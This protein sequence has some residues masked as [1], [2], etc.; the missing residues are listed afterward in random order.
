MDEVAGS[1]RHLQINKLE[2]DIGVLNE[3]ALEAAVFSQLPGH[4]EAE[5]KKTLAAGRRGKTPGFDDDKVDPQQMPN[6][7]Y[8]DSSRHVFL[9]LSYFLKHGSF[10]W[11]AASVGFDKFEKKAAR[12]FQQGFPGLAADLKAVLKQ[13]NPATER[14]SLQFSGDFLADVI[15]FLTAGKKETISEILDSLKTVLRQA[16][17]IATPGQFRK[18]VYPD[19][20]KTLVSSGNGNLSPQSWL[21]PTIRRLLDRSAE[22]PPTDGVKKLRTHTQDL[23]NETVRHAMLRVIASVEREGVLGNPAPIPSPQADL[24]KHPWA[25]EKE[26]INLFKSEL[27]RPSSARPVEKPEGEN[28]ISGVRNTSYESGFRLRSG[29]DGN[30]RPDEDGQEIHRSSNYLLPRKSDIFQEKSEDVEYYIDN[31]GLVILAPFFPSFFKELKI[32]DKGVFTSEAAGCR[33][34]HIMQ[35]AI[36]NTGQASENKLIL[37]KILCNIPIEK[38]IE[39]EIELTDEEKSNV[40]DLLDSVIK[41]WTVL[42]GTSADGLR[43]GFLQRQGK[44]QSVDNGWKLIV[45]RKTLDILLSKIPWAFSIIKLPWMDSLVF[46]EW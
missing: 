7:Q 46:V 11:W 32:L 24:R 39:R 4:I 45:E 31:A 1:E 23:K 25:N 30:G 29:K 36:N 35:Y 26:K 40:G 33:A 44:L 8:L 21:E 27:E 20:L 5:L 17:M 15:S 18:V 6:M 22:Y 14:L 28:L 19:I 9:W 34:V 43:E 41:H 10:P 3:A 38:P 16:G 2:I 42:K 12:L 37:N 13:S